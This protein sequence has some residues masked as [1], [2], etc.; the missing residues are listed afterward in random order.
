MR[1]KAIEIHADNN[2]PDNKSFLKSDATL[3]CNDLKFN[4][5]KY[6]NCPSIH[7]NYYVKN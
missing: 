7:Y 2:N 6:L 1:N 5:P 4:F 3:K